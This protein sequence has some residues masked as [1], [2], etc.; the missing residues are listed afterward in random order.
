MLGIL[1]HSRSNYSRKIK[2]VGVDTMK[3]EKYE[4]ANFLL[5]C[6][7]TISRHFTKTEDAHYDELY[8][9]EHI[10]ELVHEY[11]MARITFKQERGRRWNSPL[12]NA[13][14]L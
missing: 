11:S 10:G 5:A 12:V 7:R 2:I 1:A 9:I 6:E 14:I 8:K 3:N 4:L 13:G